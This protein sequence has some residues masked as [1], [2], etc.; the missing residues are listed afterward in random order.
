MRR[1]LAA[2]AL[3]ALAWGCR[4]GADDDAAR[5]S[6][7]RVAP[8]QSAEPVD[9]LLPD[10]LAPGKA[11]VFGFPVPRQMKV[12]R[13]YPD[14][15]HIVGNVTPESLANYVRQ[16]VE[17]IHVEIGAARTVFPA[18]RIKG[19]ATQHIYRIEVVASTGRTQLVI[20]DI[21]PP[22]TVQGLT[23]AERWKRAGLTPDGKI[24][25]PRSLE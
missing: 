3:G 1:V 11:V 9:R 18:A 7:A 24:I 12:E 5:R 2:L 16:R 21:T 13:L 20:R 15:A 23:E 25:D 17:A 22:P 8:K 6:A 4:S 14:A 10:E 19:D